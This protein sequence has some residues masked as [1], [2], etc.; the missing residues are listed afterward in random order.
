MDEFSNRIAAQ[1]HILQLV[2]RKNCAKEELFGLSSKAIDRWIAAN[3][4]DPESHL[5]SLLRLLPRSFSFLPTR[6]KSTFRKNT[7]WRPAK[8][9]R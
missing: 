7:R 6:V 8:Y 1:R 3:H 4:I 2:N 9:L 5:V